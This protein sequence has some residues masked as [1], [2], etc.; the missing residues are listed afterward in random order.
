MHYSHNSDEDY[1][2]QPTLT[3][4]ILIN[5]YVLKEKTLILKEILN[6]SSKLFVY[7]LYYSSFAQVWQL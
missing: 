6:K 1:L 5:T 4:T 3:T 2:H 7:D